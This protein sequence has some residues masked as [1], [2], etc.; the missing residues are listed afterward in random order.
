MPS[1]NIAA[2]EN[3]PIS[4]SN[5]PSIPD[6]NKPSFFCRA[7]PAK[8]GILTLLLSSFL[9][10]LTVLGVPFMRLRQG[11]ITE[12]YS[13]FHSVSMLWQN[14]VY[15]LAILVVAFSV[16][17]PFIKLTILTF[18]TVVDKPGK[19][20][21]TAFEWVE[22]LGKWSML[23][24]FLVGIILALTSGQ[25]MVGSTPELGLSLFI[26][27]ILLSMA[28][29]ELRSR[30]LHSSENDRMQD[31]FPQFRKPKGK[32]WAILSGVLLLATLGF[33]FLSIRDWRL[34]DENY[35][36]LSLV[37]ELA[38]KEA[39]LAALLVAVFL[40][41][42]PLVAWAT[43][44]RAWSR[45][46]TAPSFRSRRWVALAHRWSMLEVFALA[47]LVFSLESD[48]LM[49]TSLSWGAFF[50]TLT[51]ILQKILH[52]ALDRCLSSG[53]PPV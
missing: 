5:M 40:V 18:A 51:L 44:I 21:R 17:F 4:A 19:R 3:L 13:L 46:Q 20:L 52:G 8:C 12:D 11:W 22:K 34:S 50:L 41:W 14:K 23:D 27:A 26:L 1:H 2:C 35:S 43:S 33:P 28:A 42:S 7:A 31:V 9:L 53:K 29:G 32:R 38:R 25:F 47:L 49:H 6:S 39:W 48:Q 24:A 15:F 45:Q 36:I 30:Q 10:N 37:P 16:V